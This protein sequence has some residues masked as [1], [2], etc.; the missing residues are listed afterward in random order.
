MTIV[1][2]VAN[3]SESVNLNMSLLCVVELIGYMTNCKRCGSENVV[4]SGIVGNRQRF[5]CKECGCIFRLGDNRTD[6]KIAA[7]STTHLMVRC[8]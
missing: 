8:G 3:L 4:K 5:R 7:K 1:S 2:S 6:G